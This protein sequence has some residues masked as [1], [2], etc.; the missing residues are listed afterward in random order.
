MNSISI[1]SLQGR[2][3]ISAPRQIS[4]DDLYSEKNRPSQQ[5]AE[6]RAVVPNGGQL[7]KGPDDYLGRLM[8]L[9]PAEVVALYLTFRELAE[10]WIGVWSS[11][12]LG[13]VIVVRVF[14]T[15][16]PGK[17]V[18]IK[19]VAISAV[20]FVLWVYAIGGHFLRWQ[21][22]DSPTGVISVAI[23]VWTF[24]VPMLY[25]GD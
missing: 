12:C 7:P 1:K 25:R 8:K 17:P 2:Y 11:I 9:I 15:T 22:P 19:A 18:Q 5:N 13:L 14:G 20:S 21:L 10:G 6:R 3:R 4:L 23:G 16:V 24:I